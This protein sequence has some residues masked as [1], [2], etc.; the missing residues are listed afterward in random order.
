MQASASQL[1]RDPMPSLE[2][3]PTASSSHLIP[4]LTVGGDLGK[5]L[6]SALEKGVKRSAPVPQL[7]LAYQFRLERQISEETQPSSEHC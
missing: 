6:S 7:L 1:Q 4:I 5:C 2:R 3:L